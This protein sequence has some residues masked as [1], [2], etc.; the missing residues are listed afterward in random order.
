MSS[1]KGGLLDQIMTSPDDWKP[2]IDQ[3][4]LAVLSRRP[5]EEE[6]DKFAEF[7]HVPEKNQQPERLREALW[8]LM[9]CSEFRFNH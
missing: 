6:R 1:E 7:C 4:Y 5:R 8:V 3:L 2:R 9:T